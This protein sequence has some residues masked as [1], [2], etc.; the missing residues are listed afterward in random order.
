MDLEQTILM[1]MQGEINKLIVKR[2]LKCLPK[3]V[4]LL[5]KYI[6]LQKLSNE[7]ILE[8]TKLSKKYDGLF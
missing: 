7:D 3:V 2:D 4:Y 8:L 5:K 1:K 6:S